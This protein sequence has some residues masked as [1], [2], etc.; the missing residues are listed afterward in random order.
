MARFL[1]LI[2]AVSLSGCTGWKPY[3]E[4]GL[5]I[6]VNDR[7]DWI[8]RSGRPWQGKNPKVI[9]EVGFTKNKKSCA[10]KHESHLLSGAPFNSDPEIFEDIVYC[11]IRVGGD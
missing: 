2:I 9:G 10:Y 5:G 6:R 11:K 8:A 7:T 1:I 4:L 3:G